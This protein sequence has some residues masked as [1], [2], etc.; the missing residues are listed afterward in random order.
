MLSRRGFLASSLLAQ[1]HA[2]NATPPNVVLILCDDLGYGDAAVYFPEARMRTPNIDRL[3][4]EGMRFTDA[5]SPSSVCTPTRYGLLTGRYAWRTQLKKGVL[6]GYSP[7]LIEPGRETIASLLKKRGYRTGGFGKWHLGLGTAAKTDYAAEFRPSPN[8]Y[9][10]DE[11]F[12]IPASLDMPPYLYFRNRRTVEQPTATIAD[13][14]EVKRG[15]FWRGGP[16]APSFKMDQVIPECT[17]R[18]CEFLEQSSTPAFVY[19]ALTGPHTPW[20][21]SAKYKDRSKAGLYGD[22]VEEVDGAIGQVMET[23]ARTGKEKNT[24]LIVTSD[25]G[26]T[27][28][29]RDA[30]EAAGHMANA[31]WRGQKADIQ[32]A[33]HRIPFLVRWP[34][35]VAP[36]SLSTQTVCLTDVFATVAGAV[37]QPLA[38]DMAEDSFSLLPELEGRQK[39]PLRP[40][41]VHHS[42]TGL[43]SVRQGDWKLVLGRGSGGFTEPVEILVR[44]GEPEGELYNLKDDPHEDNDL[45]QDRPEV[46][47]RLTALLDK[48]K[49]AG[50]SR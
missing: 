23:L 1:A 41:I 43:F 17:R 12:G 5:H 26:A 48:W 19:L 2:Q 37:G 29:L 4:R 45:Y 18:A 24:L 50:R 33:G 10:F 6:Q 15:P 20:V 7:A 42:S 46:V 34:G 28:E 22:F 31:N 36:R 11:Y 9:G 30:K 8:D 49:A 3:A 38:K 27:W 44:P 39:G 14:G 35:R 13:N 47:A 16:I 25:N 21:P 40:G 32:E